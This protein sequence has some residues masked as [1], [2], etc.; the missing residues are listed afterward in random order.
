ME[1]LQPEAMLLEALS[2]R[3]LRL[4]PAWLWHALFVGEARESV[5]FQ[6]RQLAIVHAEKGPLSFLDSGFGPANEELSW[7]LTRHQGRLD[8][9]SEKAVVVTCDEPRAAVRLAKELQRIAE[10]PRRIAVAGGPCTV[11]VYRVQG[12]VCQTPVGALAER[13]ER[14]AGRAMAR[15]LAIAPEIYDRVRA[16]IGAEAQARGADDSTFSGLRGEGVHG[17]PLPAPG[18]RLRGGM[19]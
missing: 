4:G 3:I 7:L 8:P 12:R 17:L 14:L 9:C 15:R 19:R 1:E 18:P 5:S 2:A 16:E 6:Q 13:A 11:A 10:P